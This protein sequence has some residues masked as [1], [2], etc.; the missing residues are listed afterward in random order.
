MHA[1]GRLGAL[2][3]ELAAA[4]FRRLGFRVL[5]RNVSA[6]DGEIDL[7]AFDGRT[8]VFAE[9]K[10][11]R[12]AGAG[13]RAGRGRQEAVPL[14][15]LQP[16]QRVRI[17]RLARAWLADPDRD[18]PRAAELRFDAVG[19]VVDGRGRL[20]ALEHLEGAW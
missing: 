1:R 3:E 14:D 5:E 10:T 15:W 18:H 4:H 11:A 8:L 7:I 2:G 20:L 13:S 6:R 17:R 9:V 16:R 19:V 12:A